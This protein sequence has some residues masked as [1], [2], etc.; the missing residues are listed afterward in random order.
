MKVWG[1]FMI[2]LLSA[3]C[4]TAKDNRIQQDA[5]VAETGNVMEANNLKEREWSLIEI[6]G[7]PVE[8]SQT[9]DVPHLI[10]KADGRASGSG[11]CN[12]FLGNYELPGL[13]RIKFSGVVTT[14]KACLNMAVEAELMKVL[15]VADNYSLSPDGKYLSLNR[16]RMAPLARFEDRGVKN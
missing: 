11:G 7:K 2:A 14:M 15:S 6:G 5:D 13:L 1:I 10:L 16:A 9:A 4:K 3:S 8:S 12:A